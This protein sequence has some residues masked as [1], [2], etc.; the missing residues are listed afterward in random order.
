MAD[1]MQLRQV[2]LNIILNACEAMNNAG[3]LTVTTALSNKRKKAVRVEIAD[4]GVGIDEKDLPKIFDPFFTSKEKG[5]GLG[6]SVVYGIINSHQ[7]TIEVDSKAGKGTTIT[8]TLPTEIIAT[9]TNPS[10]ETR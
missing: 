10:L 5:T 3:V 2:F 6:L 9:E 1:P 8:I 4:S 7:G